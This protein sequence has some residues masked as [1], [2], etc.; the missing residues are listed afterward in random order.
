MELISINQLYRSTPLL[1]AID[2]EE[3]EIANSVNG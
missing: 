2:K 3:A 1:H